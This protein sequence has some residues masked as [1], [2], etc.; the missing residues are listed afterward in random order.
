MLKHKP[1]TV[2][3]LAISAHI[4]IVIFITPQ[5]MT[6]R[7]AHVLDSLVRVSRRVKWSITFMQWARL[8]PLPQETRGTAPS[9]NNQA[10]YHVRTY[11]Q[12]TICNSLMH[13]WCWHAASSWHAKQDTL[14]THTSPEAHIT[15]TLLD[16]CKLQSCWTA[17]CHLLSFQQFQVLVT[18]FSKSFSHFPHGTC[19]LSVSNIYLAS[20]EIYHLLCTP[21]PRNTILGSIP[22]MK[23]CT[24]HTRVSPSLPHFPKWLAH[25]L[26][27]ATQLWNTIPDTKYRLSM[28]AL[29]GSFAITKGILFSFLSSTYLYA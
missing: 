27:L 2:D 13:V 22:C 20:H 23:A 5:M 28:W 14:Y 17:S 25:T 12:H 21:I 11:S 4:P 1:L 3:W 16:V 18:F 6:H 19:T 15:Y 8:A 26:S 10:A 24:W 7:F 29:P 9:D